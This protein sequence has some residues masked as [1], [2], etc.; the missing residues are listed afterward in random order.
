MKFSYDE[1][2]L[3]EFYK[4]YQDLM[5]FWRLEK[6]INFIDVSY[7]ELIENNETEI[8]RIIEECELKWDE[9]C[10]FHFENKNPIKTMSTAQA[11][12]PIYKSSINSFD[13]YKIFLNKIDKSF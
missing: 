11:R 12:K 3:I 13:K 10:L 4:M 5:K 7:E 2:D 1:D 6:G 8:K 9:K